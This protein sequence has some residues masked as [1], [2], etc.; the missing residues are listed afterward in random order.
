MSSESQGLIVN[1]NGKN[2][3]GHNHN[4]NSACCVAGWTT[5]AL[6]AVVLS[7][8][9]V[10]VAVGWVQNHDDGGDGSTSGFVADDGCIYTSETV[11]D[12]AKKAMEFYECGLWHNDFF[13][14]NYLYDMPGDLGFLNGCY[15]DLT[16]LPLE[17]NAAYALLLDLKQDL[18]D[19]F[20]DTSIKTTEKLR[21]RYI[22]NEVTLVL[23]L[24]E[25][26]H[27]FSTFADF[28]D[29]SSWYDE[30]VL[31]A[32]RTVQSLL[33][34][35]DL[36]TV[37][38]GYSDIVMK[39]MRAWNTELP[40]WRA[41]MVRAV[42][43]KKVHGTVVMDVQSQYYLAA[44]EGLD[45]APICPTLQASYQ[46]ECKS[47]AQQLNTA[48]EDFLSYYTGTYLQACADIRPDEK[49]GLWSVPEGPEVYQAWLNY[50]LGYVETAKNIYNI[51]LERV[52]QNKDDLLATIQLIDP[53]IT[54][55]EEA[56]LAL[57]DP[58]DS[59]W[60]I[61]NN[62]T[63]EVLNYVRLLMGEI[64]DQLIPE[65]GY[66]AGVRVQPLVTGSPQTVSSAGAYDHQRNFWIVSPL[67]IIGQY[68]WCNPDNTSVQY[69]YDRLQMATVGHEAMPGHGN[70]LQI[71]AEVDCP[72]A[73]PYSMGTTSYY[74]GWALYVESD[75]YV[76]GTD[77]RGPKGLYSD[78][79]DELSYFTGSMLRNARLVVDPGMHGDISPDDNW[80]WS[81][82]V[83][84]L[85]NDGFSPAY[86][87]N[88]CERYVQ[89]PG[90]ATAYMIGGLSVSG[91]RNSTE[92]A[93]GPQFDPAEFHNALLRWGAMNFDE[94]EQL[95][96]TYIAYTLNPND[97]ALDSMFASDLIQNEMYSRTRPC[98]GLGR[99]G[100][101]HTDYPNVDVDDDN[102]SNA[103]G[104]ESL[105]PSVAQLRH[106]VL[107]QRDLAMPFGRAM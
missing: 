70:Q 58:N 19:A 37:Q 26:G 28:Y 63:T 44:L 85:I 34:Y 101:Q 89:M 41:A 42:S 16:T 88:E 75:L 73:G 105:V 79:T 22:D 46:D 8:V 50:H 91:L 53:T 9:V 31:D 14:S 92:Q 65:F 104:K 6:L 56:S 69:Y 18:L 60:F 52:A 77:D 76:M 23:E 40:L 20:S 13:S 98:V 7:A 64:E 55:F 99:Y 84:E 96:D 71:E 97:P 106:S 39:W 36:Y 81:D 49:S 47:L 3:G 67:Y 35:T 59:R 11:V 68:Q 103:G 15:W 86:S 83:T 38:D 62:D 2:K 12:I 82:C 43:E 30:P 102:G 93:L 24:V 87:E 61:C 1:H 5:T 100:E 72:I 33:E 25:T 80:S 29:D 17:D 90:Q 48:T 94:L 78:P 57:T 74:E 32:Y 54:T 45:Y 27:F 21:L 95:V 107:R 51:G 10:V 4:H 66:F